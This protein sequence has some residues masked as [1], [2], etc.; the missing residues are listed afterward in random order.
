[1]QVPE[2]TMAALQYDSHEGWHVAWMPCTHVASTVCPAG[3]PAVLELV[4]RAAT[5]ES[6][7]AS[8]AANT[9]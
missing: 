8:A 5:A 4:A 1:M 6:A 9:V 2:N 7:L 3:S